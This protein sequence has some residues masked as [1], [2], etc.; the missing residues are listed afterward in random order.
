MKE[1]KLLTC[2]GCGKEYLD[3]NPYGAKLDTYCSVKC[4]TQYGYFAR[5]GWI[6]E[7]T[8]FKLYKG[9]RILTKPKKS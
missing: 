7:N 4:S 6:F 9:K 8:D 3:N 1:R 2:D 5:T